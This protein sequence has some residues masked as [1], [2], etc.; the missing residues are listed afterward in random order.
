ML[1][2]GPSMENF[3]EMAEYFKGGK[4]LILYI[5]GQGFNLILTLFVAWIMFFKIFPNIT[6]MI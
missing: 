6:A 5:F 2:V 1:I 3:R 4:P